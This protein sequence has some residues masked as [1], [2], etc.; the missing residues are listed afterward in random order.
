M[1]IVRSNRYGTMITT[2]T[3]K[4]FTTINDTE[5]E[6]NSELDKLLNEQDFLKKLDEF[7]NK[8]KHKKDTSSNDNHDHNI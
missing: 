3:K 2:D 5:E 1:H 6:T 7:I 4:F 8:Q